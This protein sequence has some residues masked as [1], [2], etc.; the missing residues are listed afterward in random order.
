[1]LKLIKFGAVFVL[2]LSVYGFASAQDDD[3]DDEA[4]IEDED[5]FETP[6]ESSDDSAPMVSFFVLFY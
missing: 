3:G 2:L 1:M 5:D 6:Q 4:D